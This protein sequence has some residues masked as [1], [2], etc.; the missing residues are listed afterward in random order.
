MERL[1]ELFVLLEGESENN[2]WIED[3]FKEKL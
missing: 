1:V 3:L 2:D